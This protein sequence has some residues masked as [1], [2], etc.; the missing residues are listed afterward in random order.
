[1]GNCQIDHIRNNL[2]ILK[3]LLAD[4]S[5][6]SRGEVLKLKQTL[7][8]YDVDK[9]I[10]DVG[11]STSMQDYY[12]GT[13]VYVNKNM[14][15]GE[16][17]NI[18]AGDVAYG[19]HHLSN[20]MNPIEIAYQSNKIKNIAQLGTELVSN[21]GIVD[22]R[23]TTLV[24]AYSEVFSEFLD[25]LGAVFENNYSAENR[26][27]SHVYV[28]TGVDK[29][30]EKTTK[31]LRVLEN[32]QKGLRASF[33]DADIDQL[34]KSTQ[35][36][37]K[38]VES[39]SS[40]LTSYLGNSEGFI[41]IRSAGYTAKNLGTLY[42]DL[43]GITATSKKHKFQYTAPNKQRV[44]LLEKEMLKH[45][46]SGISKDN[47]GAKEDL[48]LLLSTDGLG[49][50]H[51]LR[52]SINENTVDHWSNDFP[53]LVVKIREKLLEEIQQLKDPALKEELL[54]RAKSMAKNKRDY[55]PL[56]KKAREQG[57][58]I[59]SVWQED[60]SSSFMNL[61]KDLESS[62][63]Y[64]S[65]AAYGGDAIWDKIVRLVAPANKI[66]HFTVDS[67][68]KDSDHTEK[69]HLLGGK[70]VS[71]NEKLSYTF[72]ASTF[73]SDT[74]KLITALSTVNT[75]LGTTYSPD[76]TGLLQARNL[77]QVI[78]TDAVIAVAPITGFRGVAGGTNTAVQL[79]I[80]LQ[81]PVYVLNTGINKEYPVVGWYK[82]DPVNGFKSV[83]TDVVTRFAE[84]SRDKK[85]ALVGTRELENRY[86]GDLR[87][88]PN[89]DEF[90]EQLGKNFEAVGHMINFIKA[91]TGSDVDLEVAGR[92]SNGTN[93]FANDPKVAAN[94][95]FV[96]DIKGEIPRVADRRT[97]KQRENNEPIVYGFYN[98][99]FN[100]AV[101]LDKEI[102]D[103][104]NLKVKYNGL[105]LNEYIEK[106]NSIAKGNSVPPTKHNYGDD[107]VTIKEP[108]KNG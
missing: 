101:K 75:L 56:D 47:T 84:E 31:L 94:G 58:N 57:K 97:G 89:K 74:R 1:M 20:I 49:I 104:Y 3:E 102:E 55:S 59:A 12:E 2:E 105:T 60:P 68:G 33:S 92:V 106:G 35:D 69:L 5:N 72:N 80:K 93:K 48:V 30:K 17:V 108:C 9:R 8:R 40:S 81:R 65:G 87:K 78:Y 82:Y 91:H 22:G 43:L 37:V 77:L 83:G 107:H 21:S 6:T 26:D 10:G 50:T 39:I 41:N 18:A 4:T 11:T 54:D 73:D 88:L 95:K 46:R 62:Y 42:E 24:K 64:T 66:V 70:V 29:L 63:A 96:L 19:Y 79:G 14:A 85:F 38:K 53:A 34:P 25:E 67:E 13:A 44:E 90:F 32:V 76:I 52:D 45:Y 99:W 86:Q 100:P 71:A 98:T 7:V 15:M 23:Y 103:A 27:K 51:T 28:K 61:D 36:L 16:F